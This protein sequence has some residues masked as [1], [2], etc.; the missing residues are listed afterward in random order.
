MTQIEVGKEYR[1][2]DSFSHVIAHSNI[3]VVIDELKDIEEIFGEISPQRVVDS[4]KNK[5]SSLH[6][7]FV[8]DDSVAANRYRLQQAS[9]LLRNIEVKT[10]SNG[11]VKF[12]RVFELSSISNGYN[13]EG[14]KSV[15]Y[16][17]LSVDS[18][19]KIIIFSTADIIRAVNKL[20]NYPQYV[21]S[22]SLLKKAIEEIKTIEYDPDFKVP[23]TKNNLQKVV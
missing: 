9:R 11:D 2:N 20:S 8:W 22:V 5:K 23:E 15:S 17:N 16:D 10:I 3:N 18:I 12:L 4:A 21:N 1:W 7:F 19:R 6:S 13:K 14:A